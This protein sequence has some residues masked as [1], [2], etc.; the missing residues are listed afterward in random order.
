MLLAEK[1]MEAIDWA[2]EQLD[3]QAAFAKV[4]VAIAACNAA[5]S[6][7]DPSALAINGTNSNNVHNNNN[8]TAANTASLEARP[9]T[10]SST[11]TSDSNNVNA[12][13]QPNSTLATNQDQRQQS[14]SVPSLGIYDLLS[15]DLLSFTILC[16]DLTIF[17]SIEDFD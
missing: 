11:T 10:S 8:N 14:N 5:N 2:D 6:P 12:A 1:E 17:I 7:I 9:P 15:Y 13:S 4:R 16:Y 3:L